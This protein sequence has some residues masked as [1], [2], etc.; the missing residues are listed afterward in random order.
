[1]KN[2]FLAA[3]MLLSLPAFAQTSADPEVRDSLFNDEAFRQ[4][5]FDEMYS[6]SLDVISDTTQYSISVR[7]FF[8]RLLTAPQAQRSYFVDI[9]A[10]ATLNNS[11]SAI[12]LSSGQSVASQVEYILKTLGIWQGPVNAYLRQ[13]KGVYAFPLDLAPLQSTIN[14]LEATITDLEA[15]IQTLENQQ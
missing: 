9:I 4:V 15:R 11:Q 13:R 1:M 10:Q 14:S 7:P 6:I 5:V 12:D 3:L 2:I 8:D